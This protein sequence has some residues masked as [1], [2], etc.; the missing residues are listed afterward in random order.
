MNKPGQRP[1]QSRIWDWKSSGAIAEQDLGLEEQRLQSERNAVAAQAEEVRKREALLAQ[2]AEIEAAL[3]QTLDPTGPFAFMEG[4]VALLAG[5]LPKLD[6]KVFDGL[7]AACNIE[8][9]NRTNAAAAASAADTPPA[10]PGATVSGAIGPQECPTSPEEA[11]RSAAASR[12]TRSVAQEGSSA[13][14]IRSR[15]NERAFQQQAKKAHKAKDADTEAVA[16]AGLEQA[17]S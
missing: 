1:S 7:M 10:P 17:R 8:R 4:S 11:E 16:K 3:R 6:P 13:A 14:R 5:S 9:E 12:M 15:S 2:A